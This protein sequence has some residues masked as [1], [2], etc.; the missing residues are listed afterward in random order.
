MSQ[1]DELNVEALVIK[2]R[3]AR[4]DL[5]SEIGTEIPID[6]AVEYPLLVICT[7]E[8]GTEKPEIAA[9]FFGEE[10]VNEDC[11]FDD[12]WEKLEEI[13]TKASKSL[14]TKIKQLAPELTGTIEFE[15]DELDGDFMMW[16]IET[17][18]H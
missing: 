18:T 3:T 10:L 13:T 2:I 14:T 15:C 16:Y 4:D 7:G 12:G 9:R 17:V 8:I 5:A 1:F 11:E 6:S